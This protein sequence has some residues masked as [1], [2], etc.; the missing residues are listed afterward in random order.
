MTPSAVQVTRKRNRLGNNPPGDVGNY[1][2]CIIRNSMLRKVRIL[3]VNSANMRVKTV[4]AS[5]SGIGRCA[6]HQ[7]R[8]EDDRR[9]K[10][11]NSVA[12][13]LN[14][15]QSKVVRGQIELPTKKQR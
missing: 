15:D 14:R 12:I 11:V 5:N 4:Q 8:S 6:R 10:L 1:T 13:G 2:S 7:K 3:R 9:M